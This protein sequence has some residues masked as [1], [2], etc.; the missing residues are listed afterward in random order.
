MNAPLFEVLS[1]FDD[2]IIYN[3][4]QV[5]EACKDQL[6]KDIGNYMYMY[7]NDTSTHNFKHIVTR[8]YIEITIGD[9]EGSEH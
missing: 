8:D 4:Q 6:G 1:N 2:L 7:S 9:N 3:P 5:F